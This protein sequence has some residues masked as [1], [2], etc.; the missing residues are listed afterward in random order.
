VQDG[1]PELWNLVD[2]WLERHRLVA[3]AKLIDRYHVDERL[4]QICESLAV[5]DVTARALYCQWRTQL[6]RSDTAIDRNR[7]EI[8][9]VAAIG[10]ERSCPPA[11]HI[12]VSGL[13]MKHAAS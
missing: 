4:A 8:D 1:A 10:H 6:D 7:T 11:W 5:D 12:E 3:T 2:A 9:P 13:S